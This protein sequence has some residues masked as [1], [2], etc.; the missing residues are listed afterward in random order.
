MLTSNQSNSQ[1]ENCQNFDGSTSS[2]TYKTDRETGTRTSKTCYTSIDGLTC[3]RECVNG[4]DENLQ[5]FYECENTG[6][7]C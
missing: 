5:W 6:D 4:Y 3:C 2:S 1:T 7:G